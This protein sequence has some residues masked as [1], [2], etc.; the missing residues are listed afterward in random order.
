MLWRL[1][2]EKNKKEYYLLKFSFKLFFLYGLEECVC[3]YAVLI[4]ANFNPA[5]LYVNLNAEKIQ[6]KTPY[7]FE[8]GFFKKFAAHF[9]FS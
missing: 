6:E 3:V 5:K 4:G 2:L 9:C 8:R 7:L 1:F